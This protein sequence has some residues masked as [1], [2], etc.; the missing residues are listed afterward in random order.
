MS[1]F[2]ASKLVRN[3]NLL[4]SV[5]RISS[6]GVLVYSSKRE[7]SSIIPAIQNIIPNIQST[8][9]SS[10]P[11]IAFATSIPRI[12]ILLLHLFF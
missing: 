7:I 11:I 2:F 4:K 12:F 3:R 1:I 6:K 9:Y 8:L 5:Q 10:T